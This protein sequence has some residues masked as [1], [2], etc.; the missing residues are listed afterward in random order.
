VWE[1]K[2]FG[3]LKQ[4]PKDDSDQDGLSNLQEF[5]LG[6]NP[7]IHNTDSDRDGL[8]DVWERKYFGNLKQ[9][10]KDDSD[11]DGLSNLQ[12]FNSGTDPTV[13]NTDS[14]RDGLPDVRHLHTSDHGGQFEDPHHKFP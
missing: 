4:E 7:T 14:D 9:E 10:P 2:Y 13:H 3:N 6:T 1:R 5:N 8:P 12:E 11:Q